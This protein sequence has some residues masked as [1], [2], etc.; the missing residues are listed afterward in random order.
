M[1]RRFESLK[2]RRNA[3]ILG[4]VL[5]AGFLGGYWFKGEEPEV[6]RAAMADSPTVQI[7]AQAG[8]V[9]AC[10]MNDVPPMDFPGQ[11]PICG[12]DLVPVYGGTEKDK[13]APRLKLTPEA[14]KLAEIQTTPVE[15]KFVSA[16][17]RLFGQIDYDP[18]HVTNITAFM[19]GVIDRVY[20]KRA[21][22]F[23]RWGDPLFD[24]Y[25]S[26]LLDTQK[27]IFDA[28][29]YV[30]SFFAF[31]S[32][33]PHSAKE[34]P[35]QDLSIDT[36]G[37]QS[38][39]KEAALKQIG[40]IRNKLS[41]LGMPKRDIDEL[42][43]KGEATGIATVYSSVYGQVI[44]QRAFEG[45]YINTGTS[46]FV[47]GDPRYV[48]AKLDAYEADYPWL[49]MSQSVVFETDAY[50][51]ESFEAKV[52]FI[53]PVFNAKARTFSVGAV[54]PDP[55]GRL[56]A[57]ML[58]R[59][60]VQAKLTDEGRVAAEETPIEK[61]PLVIPASAPL[62]TGKRSVVYVRAP[63]EEGTFEGREIK[64][65]PRSKSHYIVVS[66]V[67]EGEEVVKNGNFKID[68]AV[69]I[70]ARPSMM[71]IEGGHSAVSHHSHGG[72]DLMNEEYKENRVRNLMGAPKE[73]THS[74]DAFERRSGDSQ[75]ARSKVRERSTISRRRP[76]AYGDTTRP[77]QRGR[78]GYRDGGM[79]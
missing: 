22:Q 70:L 62:I 68:S 58:I 5:I 38:Q 45:S 69:Q 1:N 50:P 35:V 7:E 33:M 23:V 59:A 15:R 48:W 3:P 39:E 12:M 24:I 20:V 44:E 54:C 43:K 72:S 14:V 29:K 42:M 46:I 56:K 60:T 6:P 10:P 53:D 65:G 36:T 66:G 49:R 21:G 4:I 63:G 18:A 41:I 47:I 52:I 61:A 75:D 71:S 32:G 51:G 8:M 25:S 26:D 28:M 31:Q 11:C 9:Y 67:E 17:I 13:S 37:E 78:E 30:P 2:S 64:L 76:G 74:G 27:Q 55:G 79:K 19:P 73:P 57:G 34:M 40:A 16:E 77:G